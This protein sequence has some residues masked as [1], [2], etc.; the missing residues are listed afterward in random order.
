MHILAPDLVFPYASS[1]HWNEAFRI[2]LPCGKSGRS[3][4]CTSTNVACSNYKSKWLQTFLERSNKRDIQTLGV[5]CRNGESSSS[6][7]FK[8]LVSDSWFSVTKFVPTRSPRQHYHLCCQSSWTL[9]NRILQKNKTLHHYYRNPMRRRG[10]EITR[11]KRLQLVKQSRFA[12][13][14]QKTN[15]RSCAMCSVTADRPITSVFRWFKTTR[16]LE[17]KRRL[18]PEFW[19]GSYQSA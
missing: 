5:V 18:E 1:H 4:F 7:S 13:V 10:R 2:I 16:F 17:P 15:R 6:G 9:Y 14:R 8:S 12:S 3:S 19:R 11:M